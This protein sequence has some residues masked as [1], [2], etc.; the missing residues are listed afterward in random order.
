MRWR[1]SALAVQSIND[2]EW[3]ISGP[4]ETGKTVAALYRMGRLGYLRALVSAESGKTFL[5]VSFACTALGRDPA[6]VPDAG[7]REVL[8]LTREEIVARAGAVRS[9]L[10]FRCLDDYLAGRRYPLE[11]L[12]RLA[13]EPDS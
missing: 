12:V 2:P 3:M 10:V 11:L 6:R 4:S 1:G 5:R 7:I 8:W 13:A 9:P